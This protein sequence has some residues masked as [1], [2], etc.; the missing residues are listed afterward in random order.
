MRAEVGVWLMTRGSTQL[1]PLDNRSWSILERKHA[2]GPFSLRATKK[3]GKTEMNMK[4]RTGA[5]EKEKERSSTHRF[6]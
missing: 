4:R 3:H 6:Q 5:T 2:D 1:I